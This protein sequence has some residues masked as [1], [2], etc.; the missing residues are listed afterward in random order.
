MNGQIVDVDGL[1]RW[2]QTGYVTDDAGDGGD[3]IAADVS[4]HAV[5]CEAA[6]ISFRPDLNR[7]IVLW[8]V[9]PPV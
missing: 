8:W 1:V 2:S 5:D 9:F 6:G 7:K 4:T 3:G